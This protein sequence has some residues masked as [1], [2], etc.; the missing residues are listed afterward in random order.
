M[1]M[2]LYAGCRTTAMGTMPH[3]DID[4]ALELAMSLDIPFWPQ[5]AR[6][7]Y[8]ED[9]FVQF[10]RDFPGVTIDAEARRIVFSR[11]RFQEEFAAYS[12]RIE[13]PA[14]LAINSDVSITY[15]A[16]LKQD[17]RNYHAIR[18][19]VTGPINLGFQVIDEGGRPI[20]YD[21]DVRGIL[22]DFIQR[23]VNVQYEQLVERN[24]HAFVWLDDPGFWWVFSGVTGYNDGQAAADYAEFLSGIE[25]P[26]ALHMCVNVNLPYLLDL[27][28]DLLSVDAY[29]LETMPKEYAKALGRFIEGG[30]IV[31]WGIVP[32]E[33]NQLDIE[34]AQTLGARLTH[35]W[36]V[37][38]RNSGTTL[39]TVAEHSLLAPARCCLKSPEARGLPG[40]ETCAGVDRNN[41]TTRTEE[42]RLVETAFSHLKET[43]RILRE[44]LG[45]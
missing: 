35:Y 33:P 38:V 10:S 29:Q 24:D 44:E 28:I 9:M 39:R 3:T 41:G 17:L 16:F 34:S 20:I 6:L 40:P 2:G 45:V 42:E 30:G 22:F 27:G 26:R 5:L 23:K 43:S 12:E 19:Q 37:I 21:E 4:K 31:C 8:S 14:S 13:E 7:S 15:E 25:G 32:T 11:E 1:Y 36:E 18:G